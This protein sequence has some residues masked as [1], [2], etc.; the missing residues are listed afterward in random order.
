M[1]G[2]IRKIMIYLVLD[3]IIFYMFKLINGGCYLCW[4]Y[5]VYFYV[6]FKYICF[7]YVEVF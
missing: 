3:K 6:I 5:E 1:R 2:K 4:Y 7:K